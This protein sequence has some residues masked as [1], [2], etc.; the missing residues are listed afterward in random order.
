MPDQPDGP[1]WRRLFAADVGIVGARLQAI[2]YANKPDAASNRE[3]EGS[4][5][6][7]ALES[8]RDEQRAIYLYRVVAQAERGSVRERLF[9]DLASAASRQSDLWLIRM[10]EQGIAAP[11]PYVPDRRTKLIAALVRRFGPRRLRGVL[12]AA[13]VRGMAV[14]DGAQPGH[15]MPTTLADVGARHK[16]IAGGN[17]R[18]AVFGI[19]DGLLSNASLIMGM[20]GAS[21]EPRLLVLTGVAGLLAGAFSMASGE[22]VSVRSQREMFEYQI[23]L[24]RAE[25]EEFPQEEAAEMALI[26]AAKGLSQEQAKALAD[27]VFADPERAMATLTREELGL[28]P[29]DLGS[30]WGAA[31]SS[32]VSFAIG[33]ALPLLPF[34]IGSAAHGL[35]LAMALTA[36]SLFVVGATLSLFSG[37][38]ALYGGVRMLAIGAAAVAATYSIG[39]AI[40]VAIA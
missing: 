28:N 8:W 13:K 35:V 2:R 24:E 17:L 21:S 11:D 1:E 38:S 33:A 12:V 6:M 40:G 31:L 30:P 7:S 39:K 3:R 14:Y 16:R 5:A 27:A 32:F 34:L 10:R 23:G 26:Y 22:Y 18:A 37:R 36:A 4:V 29:D 9:E 25:L 19:N 15:P 20:A